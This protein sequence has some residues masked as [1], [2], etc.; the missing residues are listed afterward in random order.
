MKTLNTIAAVMAAMILGLTVC[1]YAEESRGSRPE[2]E[3]HQLMLTQDAERQQGNAAPEAL[4]PV[5]EFSLNEDDVRLLAALIHAEAGNQDLTGRRLV[6]D[7]VL[8]RV[9]DPA[10]PSNIVDVIYDPGQFAVVT[11]GE[12]EKALA[13][14]TTELDLQ[15]A[16]EEMVD[17][18]DWDIIGFNCGTF[19]PYL[20]PAYQYGDHF[21]TKR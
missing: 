3:L 11:N 12:L 5:E 14:G 10:F 16:R 17:Q 19:L 7:V 2:S 21:F 9:A 1:V 6:A 18:L 15:A 8:N 20:T 4:P 13:G